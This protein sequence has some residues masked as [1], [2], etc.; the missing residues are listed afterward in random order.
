MTWK[1]S[2][3]QSVE[4]RK[5]NM[6]L[7]IT[8]ED[9]LALISRIRDVGIVYRAKM[10]AGVLIKAFE[11]DYSD[12]TKALDALKAAQENPRQHLGSVIASVLSAEVKV[13]N[14]GMELKRR[15]EF[16]D[17]FIQEHEEGSDD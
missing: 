8:H 13:R 9:A 14:R 6:D 1:K 4:K 10:D 12:Y 11:R 3:T 2:H 16:V 5:C 17:K 7:V 15:L